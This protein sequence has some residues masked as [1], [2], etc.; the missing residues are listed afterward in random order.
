MLER[1]NKKAK[2]NER[3]VQQTTDNAKIILE[4]NKPCGIM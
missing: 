2:D 4:S 3:R 1:V